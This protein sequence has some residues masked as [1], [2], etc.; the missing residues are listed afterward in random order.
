[1]NLAAV[2]PCAAILINWLL[3]QWRLECP[4]AANA[5][6]PEGA[7]NNR[8]RRADYR[9]PRG[10]FSRVLQTGL[11][12]IERADGLAEHMPEGVRE[13]L[14]GAVGVDV[15]DELRRIA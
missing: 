12:E 9:A 5:R 6:R 4:T 11:D 8:L 3:D 14:Q 13:L 10:G 15:Q 2:A 7:P 1:M